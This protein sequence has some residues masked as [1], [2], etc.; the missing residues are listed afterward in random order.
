VPPEPPLSPQPTLP[1]TITPATEIAAKAQ[2][3]FAFIVSI[4]P[5]ETNPTISPV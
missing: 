1:P 3:S 2:T 5:K 4:L